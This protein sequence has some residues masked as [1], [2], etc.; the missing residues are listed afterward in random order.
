MLNVLF[1]FINNCIM[2]LANVSPCVLV[3][4]FLISQIIIFLLKYLI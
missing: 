1:L 3:Q 2:L 4:L